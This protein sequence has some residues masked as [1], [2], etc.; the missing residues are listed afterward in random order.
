[1]TTT[2]NQDHESREEAAAGGQATGFVFGAT[3]APALIE[4]IE[5]ALRLYRTPDAWRDAMRRAMAQDFSWGRAA[6]A[7]DEVYAAAM[8][9]RREVPRGLVD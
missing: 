9:A 6:A 4:A 2:R 1:M 7:Y 3:T 5:A 8:G